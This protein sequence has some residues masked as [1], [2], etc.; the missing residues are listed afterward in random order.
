MWFGTRNGL[1]RF[2]GNVFKVYQN[3][4]TDSTSIGSNS[5]FSLYEDSKE[6]LW[7]GTYKGIFIY[8]PVKESFK[9]FNLI[10]AGEVRYIKG[11]GRHHIW[12]INKY[13]FVRTYP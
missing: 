8:D 3:E 1:N 5:I 13:A 10:P 2:D 7:V 9:P 11:D 12:I 6:K 4:L